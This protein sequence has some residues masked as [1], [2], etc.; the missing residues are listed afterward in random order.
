MWTNVVAG[1][2]LAVQALTGFVIPPEEQAAIIII[3]NLILRII[4]K[5]EL[6]TPLS[7]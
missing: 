3:A 7:K 5:E 2:A 1:I 4:T 6:K